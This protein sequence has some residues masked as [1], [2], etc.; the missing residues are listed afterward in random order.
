MWQG[1]L[2]LK[3]DQAAVQMYFVSGNATVA[4]DCLP[5]NTDGTTPPLRIF[6]R[7]RLE[8]PQV[9]GVSRKMQ[10]QNE[11]CMLLALPCGH[12]HMDV[13]KQS[14]NL[15]TGFIKYLQA[16]QAAGIVNVAAPGTTH[17]VSIHHFS[18][19]V[20]FLNK[21]FYLQP[22]YVVHIF[23]SCEFVNENLRR[24]APNLLERVADIA[25]LLIVVTTV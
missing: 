8:P 2:A 21:C 9:E 4:K 22:A 3:N 15:T 24:I 11:H 7:M 6:Q 13:L 12:D 25:H 17:P 10:M 23:P 5:E 14:T 16:K 19:N 1:L 20:P 18:L